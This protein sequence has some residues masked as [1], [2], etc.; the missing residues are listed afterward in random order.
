LFVVEAELEL[1]RVI[2]HSAAQ[3]EQGYDLVEDIIK[4][5][6]DPSP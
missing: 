1:Q 5:H 2:G 6:G 3:L 4:I